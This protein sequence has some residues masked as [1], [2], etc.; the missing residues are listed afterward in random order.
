M[1]SYYELGL[2]K[3][4]T[5]FRTVP[6]PTPYG[7]PFPKIE[8]WQPQPK[9]AIA[10]ISGRGKATDSK[11]GRYIHRVHPNKSPL[12]IWRKGSAGVSRDCPNFWA[13]PIISQMGK[14]TNLQILY[15][16][17]QDRSEQK[18]VKNFG[19]SSRGRTLGLTKFFRAPIGCIARS[20]LR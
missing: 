3:S 2:R 9:T 14:A 17:S 11:F 4:A 1:K 8:G 19:K 10:I 12:Q 6:S 18:P 5:L 13:P 7:I 16:H 20:S 15:A